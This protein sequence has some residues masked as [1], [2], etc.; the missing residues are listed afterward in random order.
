MSARDNVAVIAQFAPGTL[1]FLSV[2]LTPARAAKLAEFCARTGIDPQSLVLDFLDD[3]IF[4]SRS[5]DALPAPAGG[6][7]TIREGQG[8]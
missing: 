1:S 4:S 6:Q 7:S 5:T 3:E 2:P 8:A